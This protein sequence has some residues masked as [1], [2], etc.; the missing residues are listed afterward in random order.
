MFVLVLLKN[1][2]NSNDISTNYFVLAPGEVS[3]KTIGH[4]DY[5]NLRYRYTVECLQEHDLSY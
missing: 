2:D 3:E 5:P 1:L 4:V